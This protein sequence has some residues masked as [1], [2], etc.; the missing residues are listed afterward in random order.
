VVALIGVMEGDDS[1]NVHE[2]EMN[3]V[4]LAI[5]SCPFTEDELNFTPRVRS[6]ASDPFP[7]A[8]P[9]ALPDV[10][11]LSLSDHKRLHEFYLRGDSNS[12]LLKKGGGKNKRGSFYITHEVTL[13]LFPQEFIKD[14]IL[15]FV[16]AQ[17]CDQHIPKDDPSFKVAMF[18][19]FFFMK[20]L[21]E[22]NSGRH[23]HKNVKKWGKNVLGEVSPLEFDA[24]LFL[25]NVPL[26]WRMVILLPKLKHIE[27]ICSL[28]GNV[29]HDI[30]TVW[31]W[32]NDE[33]RCQ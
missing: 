17:F 5:K 6:K 16:W 9:N 4:T 15:N 12:Y 3:P 30:H 31:R 27:G 23:E 1:N 14:D 7:L 19:S 2:S 24:I 21:D 22:G 29:E 8:L 13:S 20:L 25:R 18:T 33:L 11:P 28:N 10:A 32:L 26:H